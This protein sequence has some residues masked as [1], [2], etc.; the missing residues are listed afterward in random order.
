MWSGV[1]L[2]GGVVYSGNG[3]HSPDTPLYRGEKLYAVDATSGENLWNLTGWYEYGAV[4]DGYLVIY[5]YGDG[6]IYCFG[7][8]QTATTVSAPQT[9]QPQG[10]PILIQGT[11]TDQSLAKPTW[12]FRWLEPLQ[13]QT[14]T[15]M[16]GWSTC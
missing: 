12:A 6:R 3:E 10:T 16:N 11:I 15:W 13:S 4:A 9:V 7:K 8:G 14:N 1:I 2:A 5:N